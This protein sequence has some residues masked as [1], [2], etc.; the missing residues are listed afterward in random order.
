MEYSLFETSW[1]FCGFIAEQSHLIRFCLPVKNKATARKLVLEGIDQSVKWN[2]SSMKS[3]QSMVRRY[4]NGCKV[5]FSDVPVETRGF[6]AFSRQVLRTCRL[7]PWGKTVTYEQ[8]A[9]MAG[10][11]RAIRAAASVLANN[12]IPLIIP[13]HR[14]IRK[15]GGWGGF[16]AIGGVKLKERLFQLEKNM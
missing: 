12:P 7:I 4:F 15:D 3:L 1:G 2:P 13:C 14:V 5:N 6:S 16:S 10:K 11:P 8:L 9:R